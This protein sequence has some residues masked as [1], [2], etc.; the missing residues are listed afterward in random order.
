VEAGKL[1][2]RKARKLEGKKAG[3]LGCWEARKLES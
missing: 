2:G 1:G 3:R